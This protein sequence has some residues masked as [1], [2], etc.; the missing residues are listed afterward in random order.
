FNPTHF[1]FQT[2]GFSGAGG[3]LG[4]SVTPNNRSVMS[5]IVPGRTYLA[6]A[7]SN[8]YTGD[9]WLQ[10]LEEGDVY[11]HG[12]EPSVF[13]MLETAA[14]LI[15]GA[16]HVDFGSSLPL[17]DVWLLNNLPMEDLPR[18]HSRM[19]SVVGVWSEDAW[20]SLYWHTYMP[21]DT[22]TV[23]QGQNRTGTVFLPPRA[24]ALRFAETSFDYAPYV[25]VLPSGDMQTPDFMSRGAGYHVR[26]LNVD[27]QISF[28]EYILHGTNE[29]VY[30]SRTGRRPL[31]PSMGGR[32]AQLPILVMP[33]PNLAIRDFGTIADARHMVTVYATRVRP[34]RHVEPLSQT[35]G[36]EGF[37]ELIDMYFDGS[38]HYVYDSQ[39]F[40]RLL[41][42]FS[43][44][45]LAEYSRQVREHFMQ[46]PDITPQRV[47]DITRDIVYG[48]DND[49]A[50][51]TAIRDFLLQ[52]PYTLSPVAVPRGVCFVDFFLFEGQEGYCTYFASAMAVMARIAGVPSRYVEGF[53]TPPP[54]A[55]GEPVAITNRMAHA[56][57]EVYLEGFGW[58]TIE[59][60]PTYALLM[61]PA[62]LPAQVMTGSSWTDADFMDRM[63]DI[64][65]DWE[66]EQEQ[67]F[68]RPYIPTTAEEIPE[69]ESQSIIPIILVGA[70]FSIL[71]IAFLAMRLRINNN[72]LINQ[73]P[74]EQVLIYFHALIDIITYYTKPL[75]PSETEKAYAAHMGKRFAFR[76]DT[77]FLHD[78]IALYYKAKY[79]PAEITQD[80]AALMKEAHE[81]MLLLLRSMRHRYQFFYLRHIRRLGCI[82]G[83]G[84]NTV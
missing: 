69:P 3:R 53:V 61:S 70:V 80:E 49:F 22:I 39:G 37:I 60:T 5:V 29:G 20:R 32:S 31:L 15:R 67:I 55:L 66:I 62:P 43:T 24:T 4:G 56:W 74:R 12:L 6:G 16:T 36:I 76:S 27:T 11:T 72:K 33:M 65:S 21:M 52:F 40:M 2:T 79:S 44:E 35:P 48:L 68:F 38:I 45:I 41:D 14:A 42:T 64:M 26:F 17:A 51:V 75:T 1:R 84:R 10:A 13:E 59:A 47:F 81:D 23:T 54:V 63:Y 25:Q 46:V 50:R 73:P 57:V 78:I 58:K 19:F 82:S 9:R 71:L 8:I 83:S 30:V 34:G 7:T 28:I 18:L 77:V